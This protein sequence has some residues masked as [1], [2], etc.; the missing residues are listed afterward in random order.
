MA[1]LPSASTTRHKRLF[2]EMFSA[3]PTK[4]TGDSNERSDCDR[5]G[6]LDRL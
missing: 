1:G 6:W 5:F 3:T 2:A 4:M